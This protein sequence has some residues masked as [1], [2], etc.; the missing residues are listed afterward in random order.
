MQLTN[1]QYLQ[2]L[3]QKEIQIQALQ[4]RIQ[5]LEQQITSYEEQLKEKPN[6]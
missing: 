3:G 4:L 6:E 2:L 1:E 5:E